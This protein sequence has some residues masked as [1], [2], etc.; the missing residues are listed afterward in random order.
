MRF[1]IMYEHTYFEIFWRNVNYMTMTIT[2]TF[3]RTLFFYLNMSLALATWSTRQDSYDKNNLLFA[4]VQWWYVY[5][6]VFAREHWYVRSCII[7]S[8][9]QWWQQA[10][11]NNDK[12]L[13]IGSEKSVSWQCARKI[14]SNTRRHHHHR[15]EWI[16]CLWDQHV[17]VCGGCVCVK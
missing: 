13:Q 4:Y 3:Y 5:E 7:Y 2:L 11:I 10:N 15:N 1:V 14:A 16:N 17:M 6:V 12:T 8:F 9:I